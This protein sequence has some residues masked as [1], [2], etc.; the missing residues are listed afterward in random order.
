[1]QERLNDDGPSNDLPRNY[2]TA[3]NQELKVIA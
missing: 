2:Q 3:N 1:M